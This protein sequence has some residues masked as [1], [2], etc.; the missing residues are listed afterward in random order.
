[1]IHAF[2]TPCLHKLVRVCLEVISL[3]A[4]S[5]RI[6][7]HKTIV[8]KYFTWKYQTMLHFLCG[9]SCLFTFLLSSQFYWHIRLIST[10]YFFDPPCTCILYRTLFCKSVT[11][12]VKFDVARVAKCVVLLCRVIVTVNSA[13]EVWTAKRLVALAWSLKSFLWSGINK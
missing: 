10:A 3:A 2:M 8:T 13:C 5:H 6:F 1:M 11:R 7:K 12:V 9:R 4:F